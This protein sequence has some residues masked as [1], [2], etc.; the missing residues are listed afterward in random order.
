MGILDLAAGLAERLW[1]SRVRVG[2]SGTAWPCDYDHVPIWV[3]GTDPATR[4]QPMHLDVEL[5]LWNRGTQPVS[6]LE[7]LEAEAAGQRLLQGDEFT[8]KRFE[9]TTLVVG[10]APVLSRFNL[11]P[12]TGEQLAARAGDELKLGLAPTRGRMRARFRLPIVSRQPE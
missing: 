11:R 9:G 12:P 2:A 3:L 7:D 6:L 5:K 4:R 8:N 1:A 10:A